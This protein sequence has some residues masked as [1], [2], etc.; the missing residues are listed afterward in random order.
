MASGDLEKLRGTMDLTEKKVGRLLDI[1][2][3]QEVGALV[4]SGGPERKFDAEE[5]AAKWA[6]A[7]TLL[8]RKGG[9]CSPLE[10]ERY[11]LTTN[12]LASTASLH[13]PL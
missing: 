7:S 3:L 11:L 2:T 4:F 5:T 9:Y 12:R 8:D 13:A 6:Q 1:V 10:R